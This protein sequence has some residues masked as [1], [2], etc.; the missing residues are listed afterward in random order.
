MGF[1]SIEEILDWK[2]PPAAKIVLLALAHRKNDKTGKCYPGIDDLARITC[3]GRRTVIRQLQALEAA[4]AIV[5]ERKT[6][7]VNHYQPV[8]YAVTSAKMAPV[9]NEGV[10]PCQP[11]PNQCQSLAPEEKKENKKD[12]P[13]SPSPFAGEASRLLA[14]MTPDSRPSFA[15]QDLLR[16]ASEGDSQAWARFRG[17]TDQQT[18]RFLRS[19]A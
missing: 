4:G 11:V 19:I 12:N 2:L 15:D 16:L 1:N 8:P 5:V 18:K 3:L 10:H 13:A 6:G 7:C 9:T 17:S 14:G